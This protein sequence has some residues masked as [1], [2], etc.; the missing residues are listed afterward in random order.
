[1]YPMVAEKSGGICK[2]ST[3]EGQENKRFSGEQKIPCGKRGNTEPC[4]RKVKKEV[5]TVQAY[6]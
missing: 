2:Q 5:F 6:F 3:Q 4:R 1:M